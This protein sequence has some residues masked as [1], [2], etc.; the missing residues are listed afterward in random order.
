MADRQ[1]SE[2]PAGFKTVSFVVPGGIASLHGPANCCRS[3]GTMKD[4]LPSL[5]RK[6][7]TRVVCHRMTVISHAVL[8]DFKFPNAVTWCRS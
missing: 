5:P 3:L 2:I 8:Y 1:V 7:V 6:V 4:T